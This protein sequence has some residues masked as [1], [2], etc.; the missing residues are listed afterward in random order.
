[1]TLVVAAAIARQ[2]VIPP[3]V[4]G[5]KE[6][7]LPTSKMREIPRYVDSARN[8][9]GCLLAGT[10]NRYDSLGLGVWGAECCAPTEMNHYF[11]GLRDVFGLRGFFVGAQACFFMFTRDSR[12]VTPS[13]SRSFRCRLAYGSRMSNLPPYPTTRCHGTPFPDGL[14]AI[15]RPALRA[16]PRS[17]RAFASPP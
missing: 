13:D 2:I 4:E 14:A 12:R 10:P 5:R 17:R 9:G 1:M 6:S 3:R 16:P 8:D 15:A 11:V 7:L